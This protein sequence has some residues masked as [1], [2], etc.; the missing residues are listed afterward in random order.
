MK[1]SSHPPFL[2]LRSFLRH[3]EAQGQLLRVHTEVDPHL[4]IAAIARRAVAMEMPA[5][6]FERVRGY[7]FPVAVN[8][9]ASHKRIELA[10][11][12]DPATIGQ[13][14]HD[15][16]GDLLFPSLKAVWHNRHGLRMLTNLRLC[17]L[18]TPL[19]HPRPDLNLHSLPVLKCWPAD[20]GRFITLPLVITRDPVL[21]QV[22]VGIYRMQVFEPTST[23]MHWQLHK[24]GGFHYWKAEARQQV[25]PV[26]VA[27]GTDPATL[28]AAVAPFPEGMPE[29]ILAGL[30]RGSPTPVWRSPT[31]GLPIPATAEI[32]LEGTVFPHERRLEGPFGDHFGHY[33][34]PAP[35]PV[36]HVKTMYLRP[37]TIYVASVVGKP[38][39]EDRYMGEAVQALLNPLVRILYPEV[40]D[41]CSYYEAGFHNLTVVSAECRYP[42]EA[43]KTALGLM[44]LGQLAL[45][46]VVIMVDSNIDPR[47][48]TEVLTAIEENFDPALDFHPIYPTS[49]DTLDFTGPS[50]HWG[51]RLILDATSTP[52]GLWSVPSPVEP[53]PSGDM[54]WLEPFLAQMADYRTF[55]RALLAFK[56]KGEPKPLLQAM[57]A[58][59][60]SPFPRLIVAVSDDVDLDSRVELIWGIFTRFDPERDIVISQLHS[61][62]NIPKFRGPVGIDATWKPGYPEPV[63][64][65]PAVEEAVS[66]RWEEYWR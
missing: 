8:L 15:M 48:W 36:F 46:K 42:K 17:I 66:R 41:L 54:A 52:Q 11:G 12:R 37:G 2:D 28:L 5:I 6:L 29:L 49:L 27:I 50:L 16:A 45:A 21:N 19:F 60:A 14:L 4:E 1:P 18:S 65:D 7:S 26:A 43:L 64:G 47:N 63:E 57:V 3:L 23:G 30:L 44:G 20:G 25:L 33:S 51:S 40:R 39:Q 53:A 59:A 10:L 32:V 55:G 13:M 38:P 35:F 22:N 58:S 62:G 31:S 61:V 9:L 56:P 24:G 34:A